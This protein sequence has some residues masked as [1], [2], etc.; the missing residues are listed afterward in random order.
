EGL[1]GDLFGKRKAKI[2]GRDLRYTLEL[3]F[4]EAAL[5]CS[6]TIRFPARGECRSCRGTGGRSGAAG[7]SPCSACSGRGEIKVQQGFFSLSKRCPTCAGAGTV[8]SDPCE[9]CRGTGAVEEEREFS[10]T[11]PPGTE[12]GSTR[13]LE[14]QGEPGRRGGT[15]GDLNVIVRVRP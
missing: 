2:A 15:P 8:V 6:K 11:I 1:F 13:R 4:E 9:S 12:D 3:S 14:A 5:G 7:L 10:V